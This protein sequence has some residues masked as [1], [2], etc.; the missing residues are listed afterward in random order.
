MV[1]ANF[2]HELNQRREHVEDLFHFEG[3][4]V[5]RGTYG[6]VYKAI[7]KTEMVKRIYP[8]KEY[9]LKMI[10]GNQQFTM[11][12]CRE[13]ALLRELRHP[14]LIRLQRVFLTKERKVWL[15]LD[16]AD[17]D[18][19]HI[20]KHHRAMKVKKQPLN[21][22]AGMVKSILYQIL[23]GIHF[24]HQNWVLHRDLK[25][26][27]ILVMGEGPGVQRGRVKIA[28]MGFARVF[29]NPLKPMAELD[30]VVV[31]FWY[32]A[33]ELL[34]GTKHYTKAIDVWA[35]GCIFAE[36]LTAEPVFYCKDEDIKAQNPYHVEQLRRIFTV[37][38]FPQE[39]DWTDMKKMPEWKRLDQD[40]QNRKNTPQ[41][42]GFQ[43]C[44]L[45]VFLREKY[46]IPT[47]KRDFKLLLKLLRFDP[48][49]RLS[50][51]DA[52]DD[53]FFKEEP[54]PTDDVFKGMEIPYPAREFM[55]EGDE[56]RKTQTQAQQLPETVPQMESTDPPTAKKLRMQH[57]NPPIQMQ[58]PMYQPQLQPGPPGMMQ[59]PMQPRPM[60]AQQP[61]MQ[62]YGQQQYQQPNAQ[63]PQYQQPGRPMQPNEY[64]H[65]QMMRPGMGYENPQMMM[66]TN[67]MMMAT[68]GQS[69]MGP[70]GQYM[71]PQ[72]AQ[73]PQWAHHTQYQQ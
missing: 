71:P 2:R 52:M 69:L 24:L 66:H 51:K 42:G 67:A 3:S 61:G 59:Q 46:R 20:I 72:A 19:W 35:I 68:Q 55:A 62:M 9:A 56:E 41:N 7:P 54:K 73:Q 33:P 13:I 22:S 60:M 16:Y 29:S 57:N 47:N 48:T 64:Q 37:M 34:L 30:P 21:V 38:G 10:E 50:C 45:D 36:L 40:F 43:N 11:S 32:R 4:K 12:A 15:L 5:G 17:H 63:P 44:G 14:N 27:N 26:A 70:Q 39:A 58:Q 8:N 31:T 49:K 65:N 1:D 53:P 6:H 18:L 28:D 25:P 23:N